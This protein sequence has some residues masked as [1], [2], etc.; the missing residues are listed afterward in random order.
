MVVNINL[1]FISQVDKFGLELVEALVLVYMHLLV[2]TLSFAYIIRV[3]KV[4]TE[5]VDYLGSCL[6]R[7]GSIGLILS[8][9]VMLCVSISSV[10]DVVYT[11]ILICEVVGI[12]LEFANDLDVLVVVGRTSTVAELC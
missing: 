11:S 3:N 9:Q 6:E 10:K 12:N 8:V 1:S 5:V 2:F 4:F 7:V